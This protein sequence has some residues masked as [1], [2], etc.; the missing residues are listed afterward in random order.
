MNMKLGRLCVINPIVTNKKQRGK[1]VSL[2]SYI[3]KILKSIS[4]IVVVREGT[5]PLHTLKLFLIACVGCMHLC[6]VSSV[7]RNYVPLTISFTLTIVFTL[8]LTL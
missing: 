6:F 1:K 7:Y 5:E 3:N 4:C 8:N 2:S